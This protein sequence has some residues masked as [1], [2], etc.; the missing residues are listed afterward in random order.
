MYV[1]DMQQAEEEIT[2]RR[3][4]REAPLF[5][6]TAPTAL[7]RPT[8]SQISREIHRPAVWGTCP[9]GERE[10]CHHGRSNDSLRSRPP[11]RDWLHRWAPRLEYILH[12]APGLISK[13][14]PPCGGRPPVC[15]KCP[16][17]CGSGGPK[18][19]I[20]QFP[21]VLEQIGKPRSLWAAVKVED[22]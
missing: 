11:P 16:C 10:L 15:Q 5:T 7:T 2:V 17:A 12:R 8:L 3:V 18:D 9:R 6:W 13:V 14:D 1:G 22:L 20:T 19:P 4:G 21:Q